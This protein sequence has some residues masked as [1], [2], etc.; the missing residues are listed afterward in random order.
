MS[1]S[2][3]NRYADEIL[4]AMAEQL[5]DE[6]FTDLFHKEAS[7]NKTAGTLDA[8]KKELAGAKD[9]NQVTNI[10][11]KYLDALKEADKAAGAGGNVDAATQARQDKLKE[12]NKPG[13]A[14]PPAAADDQIE[15][16]EAVAANFVLKHLVKVAD[17]LDKQGFDAMASLLDDTIEKVAKK[18]KYK[19]WKGKEE[20][21]PKGAEHKAPK[22]WFDKMKKDVKK[23]NPEFS[24]KRVNEIVGDIW[25]NELSDKKRVEI[26]KRYGKKD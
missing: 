10:F 24:A 8:F 6:S 16:R 1:T 20:K 13:E 12:L 17:S 4:G 15:S 5:G 18:G 2:L 22:G 21:P 7:I 25:D 14:M 3:K 26:K 9:A 23:K 11:N 19:T